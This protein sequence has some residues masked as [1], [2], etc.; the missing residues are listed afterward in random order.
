MERNTE[1]VAELLAAKLFAAE[2]AMDTAFK[3]A[4][5]LA[6]YMP[7]ARQAV[8][9]SVATG[10]EAIA[11]VAQV[12]GKLGEARGGLVEAHRA[13]SRAQVRIGLP[14]RDFGAFVDKPH[15]RER[16]DGSMVRRFKTVA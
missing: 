2:N 14:E 12:L 16:A 9:A 15:R 5:D 8:C 4:A 3:S 6:S 13:L 10:H 11:S 7:V 1:Q